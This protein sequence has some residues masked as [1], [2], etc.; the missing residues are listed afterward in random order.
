MLWNSTGPLLDKPLSKATNTS[1]RAIN[2]DAESKP[3]HGFLNCHIEQQIAM[4]FL[5]KV[6]SLGVQASSD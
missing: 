6:S 4:V 5:K 2:F 1:F 3:K